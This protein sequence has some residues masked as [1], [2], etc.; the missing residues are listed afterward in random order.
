MNLGM[1]HSPHRD[2]FTR[3]SLVRALACLLAVGCCSCGDNDPKIKVRTIPGTIMKVDT[4][5][6][7]LTLRY[8]HEKS[9]GHREVEG[10]VLPETEIFINGK[11]STLADIKIGER[12][13][14]RGRIE[15][16][17]DSTKISALKID[18][19]RD[20]SVTFDSDYTPGGQ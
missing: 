7:R 10:D 16:K 9:G 18:I 12:A 6:R 3:S 2:V 20:E 15:K 5:N 17:A 1:I 11:L 19:T 14:I 13:V 4:A 8:V